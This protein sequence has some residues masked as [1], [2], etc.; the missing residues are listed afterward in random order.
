MNNL[1][2]IRLESKL[3]KKSKSI[4]VKDIFRNREQYETFNT[5]FQEH[6]DDEKFSFRYT[7]TT[8]NI[9][10]HLFE[11][12]RNGIEKSNTHL[13]KFL[14]AKARLFITLLIFSFRRVTAVFIVQFLNWKND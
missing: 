6:K 7:Y 5:L 11:L 13:K 3:K 12:V 2:K 10:N 8:S 14:P 1:K 4:W 9:F